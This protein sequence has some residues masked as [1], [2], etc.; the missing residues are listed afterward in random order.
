[1]RTT[2]RTVGRSVVLRA[3][4]GIVL[5]LAFASPA[6][7]A[8]PDIERDDDILAGEP[9]AREP[10]PPVSLVIAAAYRTAGLDRDPAR[11]FR[12][13]ARVAGLVPMLSLRAGTNTSWHV[14]DDPSVGRGTAYEARAT[15]RLD[16][17]VFDG[18]ELA[19][20]ATSAAR[21]R[22]RRRIASR[23][24]RAYFTWRRATMARV[25]VRAEEAAA[26][27]DAMTDGWFSQARRSASECRTTGPGPTATP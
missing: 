24:I 17:L 6:H 27:L 8:P 11:S 23:V 20:E 16:R 18:R 21:R 25:A 22:E 19:V 4:L 3:A 12:W 9:S 13:R 10:A 15:W 14:D 2:Q 7:A 26:E 5:A 1:M